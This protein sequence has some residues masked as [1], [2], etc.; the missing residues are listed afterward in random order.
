MGQGGGTPPCPSSSVP[1]K[2]PQPWHRSCAFL[3]C[4]P[5]GPW[6]REAVSGLTLRLEGRGPRLEPRDAAHGSA[7]PPAAKLC[8]SSPGRPRQGWG[9]APRPGAAG[10]GAE[11]ASR[12]GKLGSVTWLEESKCTACISE[13]GKSD[14]DNERPVSLTSPAHGLRARSG[15]GIAQGWR[16]GSCCALG[17]SQASPTAFLGWGQEGLLA[18]A[19][20]NRTFHWDVPR[21]AAGAERR[22]SR[23]GEEA[24]GAWGM[25]EPEQRKAMV[26]EK[27]AEV[28]AIWG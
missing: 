6:S 19:D 24:Q 1:A 8:R 21:G 25:L 3:P 28:A 2:E 22:L 5:A 7:P 4:Q 26:R 12:A 16:N 20:L 27:G 18:C 23:G 13:N 11:A 9:G 17:S 14:P 15:R 10:P